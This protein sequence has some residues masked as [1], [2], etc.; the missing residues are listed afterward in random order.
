MLQFRQ[1]F[2]VRMMGIY[3]VLVA[4]LL[5]LVMLHCLLIIRSCVV[6]ICDVCRAVHLQC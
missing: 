6:Y 3:H 4:L 2:G 5:V 1:R